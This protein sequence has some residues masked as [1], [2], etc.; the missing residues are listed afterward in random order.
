MVFHEAQPSIIMAGKGDRPRNC[1]SKQF[2]DNYE[3]IFRKTA[4]EWAKVENA[5]ID[6]EKFKS[7]G[8][9][10]EDRIS[11]NIFCKYFKNNDN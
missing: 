7:S 4:A 2:K 9:S 8:F 3:S 6:L 11:Y 10:L 5:E 1:F